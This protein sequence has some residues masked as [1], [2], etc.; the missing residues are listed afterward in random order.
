MLTILTFG[1]DNSNNVILR[2]TVYRFLTFNW[3]DCCIFVG[4][5]HELMKPIIT[6]FL[7]IFCYFW[8]NPYLAESK[9]LPGITENI[10]YAIRTGNSKSLAVYFNSTIEITLPG[11]EGTFSKVQAEMVIKDFFLK[12]PPAAFDINQKVS[13]SGGSQFIIGTYKSGNKV[14]KVYLLLKPFDGQLLIQQL[15]FEGN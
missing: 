8:F 2:L 7:F 14:Y 12:N 10:T 6:I 11:K 3:C 5:V 9:D 13:S 4:V 15:Q 1:K